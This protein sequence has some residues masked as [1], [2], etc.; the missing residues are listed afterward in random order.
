MRTSRALTKAMLGL[1]ATLALGCSPPKLDEFLY[2]PLKAP[3]GGYQL[4][5]TVIPAATPVTLPTPDGQTLQGYFIPAG[6]AY[7]D[8]TVIYFHGQ[9]NNVGTSWPRLEYLYP[10]GCNILAV[11]VRGYGL[12]TG[13]PD[14]PGI[15]IDVKTIWNAAIG[16]TPVNGVTPVA[17]GHVVVYGRSLGAAFAVQLAFSQSG[18]GAV[19]PPGALV[20]ES[21]FT[22]VAALVHD[23]AYVDLPPGFVARSSWD[24]LTKI[25]GVEADYL[26]L[27]GSAD[28]YVLP[29]YSQELTAAHASA[30]LGH[31]TQ[32]IPVPRAGHDDLPEQ[33]PLANYQNELGCVLMTIE[34]MA[35]PS[36]PWPCA[37]SFT[38]AP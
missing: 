5:T 12:S 17:P 24:N 21:A 29:R 32:L 3:A 20:T 26:A 13:S 4:S 31:Q 11:D 15:D 9:G 25:R 1:L 18:S 10:L 14:E 38:P 27:H 36:L 7:P 37:L 30:V 34:G 16:T 6:G 2:D 8:V 23:G 22:S 28:S 33:W 35:V 19:I